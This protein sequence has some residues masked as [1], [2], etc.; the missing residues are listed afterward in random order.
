[1]KNFKVYLAYV[2]LLAMVMTSCSKEDNPD[3]P[4]G[5]AGEEMVALSFT[6]ML[7]DFTRKVDSKQAVDA[8]VEGCFE[9]SDP[10]YVRVGVKDDLGDWVSGGYIDIPV[11]P[12]SVDSDGDGADNYLTFEAED[13]ELEQGDYTLEYFA[14]YNDNNDLIFMAPRSDNQYGPANFY[15]FVES[16]L[17]QQFTLNVGTKHYQEVE[18]LCYDEQDVQEY[19]YLFFDFE[20]VPLTYICIFGNECDEETG[21]H[22][23]SHFRVKVWEYPALPGEGDIEFTDA[24]A[25]VNAT[26]DFNNGENT[27]E[28][29]QADPLC[30]PLPDRDGETWFYGE[31]YTIDDEGIETLIRRGD[32]S[33]EDTKDEAF[34]IDGK[35][36]YWHFR[37]GG[38]YCGED[39]DPC[40]LS[41]VVTDWAQDF[42]T[43]VVDLT[44]LQTD[45][46][47]VDTNSDGDYTAADSPGATAPFG[48][49]LITNDPSKYYD[50]FVGAGQDGDDGNMI[51]F[52][53]SPDVSDRVIYTMETPELCEGDT[54]FL[55][56]RVK[57]ISAPDVN[58][59]RLRVRYRSGT[60]ESATTAGD[61]EI[62]SL[63][64][65]ADGNWSTIGFILTAANDG[66]MLIRIRDREDDNSGNDFAMDDIV[67]SND[68]MTLNGINAANINPSN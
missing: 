3:S 57:D 50:Q 10:E 63:A 61:F 4:D 67:L 2:A 40:L 29:V 62:S 20:E 23:P 16:P 19:G 44:D 58:N 22:K 5:P 31:I 11:I 47:D 42:G 21:R 51:V 59:A 14:V 32:F 43:G 37:Q 33:D 55:K 64:K 7:S 28:V 56:M 12:V 9:N 53:G 15:N 1:M 41:R 6:G 52:D 39:S 35:Q 27:G 8:P 66:S 68:P 54:Y 18:V 24:T 17:P 60:P 48:G 13:L 26:N 30:I 46:I 25:L 45:Y 49:Y 34:E 36:K 38:E 65:D